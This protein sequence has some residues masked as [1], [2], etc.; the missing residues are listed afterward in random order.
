MMLAMVNKFIDKNWKKKK[1]ICTM[2]LS[3]NLFIVANIISHQPQA[4]Q[5][6]GES[7]L[8]QRILGLKKKKKN[9]TT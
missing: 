9:D 2:P 4:T 3:I 7:F 5:K 8:P 6:F 1:N